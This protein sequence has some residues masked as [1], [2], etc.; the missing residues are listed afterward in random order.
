MRARAASMVRLRQNRDWSG[1][2]MQSE[3]SRRTLKED[4]RGFH[5]HRRQ[6]IRFRAWSLE[7]VRSRKARNPEIVF[8]FRIVRLEI[9]VADRPVGERS[10]WNITEE[11][12]LMK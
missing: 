7:R 5:G 11:A 8:G 12:A 6:R 3:F 4:T 1:K 9:G 10:T 2:W